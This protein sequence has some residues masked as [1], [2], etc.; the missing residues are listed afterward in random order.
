MQDGYLGRGGFEKARR[1]PEAGSGASLAGMCSSIL[2]SPLPPF[3]FLGL[4]AHHHHDCVVQRGKNQTKSGAVKTVMGSGHW[5]GKKGSTAVSSCS[6][7]TLGSHGH[8]S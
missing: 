3:S 2:M 1:T 6:S 7:G 8:P 4:V 5:V